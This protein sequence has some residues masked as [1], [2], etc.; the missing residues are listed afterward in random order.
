MEKNFKEI[1]KENLI[2]KLFTLLDDYKEYSINENGDE[3]IKH[4]L[5]IK[6]SVIYNALEF[7]V[8]NK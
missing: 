6:E 8:K 5:T 4:N 2:M 3:V 7:Y 1:T